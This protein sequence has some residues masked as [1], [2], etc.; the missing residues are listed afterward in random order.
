MT[1]LNYYLNKYCKL[2]NINDYFIQINQKIITFIN[3]NN[4][5]I[6]KSLNYIKQEIAYIFNINI[7][8]LRA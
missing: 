5:I 2:N 4:E 6:E 8:V 1:K 3:S 7:K